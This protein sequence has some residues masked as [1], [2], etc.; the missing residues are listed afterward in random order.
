MASIG[1]PM[2]PSTGPV[3]RPQKQ[4]FQETIVNARME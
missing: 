3:N 4:T 1:L 2:I